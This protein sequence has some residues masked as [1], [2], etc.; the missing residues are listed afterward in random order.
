MSRPA[1]EKSASSAEIPASARA[2]S[3]AASMPMY[4]AVEDG[5]FPPQ[6]ARTRAKPARMA[7]VEIQMFFI[8]HISFSYRSYY[9]S[10]FRNIP[11]NQ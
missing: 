2:A 9:N 6:A 4:S 8:I 10:I 7:A 3:F 5:L 11:Q 1:E